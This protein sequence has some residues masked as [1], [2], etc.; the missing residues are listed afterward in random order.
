MWWMKTREEGRRK[1]KKWKRRDKRGRKRRGRSVESGRRG[2]REG[3]KARK[4]EALAR[5]ARASWT[6]APCREAM[7]NSGVKACV[8]FSRP[9]EDVSRLASSIRLTK[10]NHRGVDRMRDQPDS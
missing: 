4:G 8:V 7:G 1:G 3:E 9:L 2:G 6:M 10:G 5:G